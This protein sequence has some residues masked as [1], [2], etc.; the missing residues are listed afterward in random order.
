VEAAERI[1][2]MTKLGWKEDWPL[3]CE[4]SRTEK[5]SSAHWLSYLIEQ[6]KSLTKRECIPPALRLLS[7]R[8]PTHSH[9]LLCM[10]SRGTVQKLGEAMRLQFSRGKGLW[11]R[12]RQLAK[13]APK[14][15]HTL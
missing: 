10:F 4:L 8:Y 5:A 11:A 15:R 13:A 9:S 1:L 2:H 12:G 6:H 7:V 14:S 3:R